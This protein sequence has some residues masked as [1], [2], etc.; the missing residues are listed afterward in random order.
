MVTRTAAESGSG[1]AMKEQSIAPTTTHLE[2][3]VRAKNTTGLRVSR[4]RTLTVKV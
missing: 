2:C 1:R 4:G 3:S